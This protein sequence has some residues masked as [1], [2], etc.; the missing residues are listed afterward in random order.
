APRRASLIEV[1]RSERD[2]V[3]AAALMESAARLADAETLAEVEAIVLARAGADPVAEGVAS[4]LEVLSRRAGQQGR[5]GDAS[6]AWLAAHARDTSASPESRRLAA[7]ALV[8]SKALDASL[9]VDLSE[10]D[11]WQLQ[12]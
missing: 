6:N 9:A 5:L 4:A 7:Q 1:L 11:D 3:V 12:R 2:P 8:T 10:A